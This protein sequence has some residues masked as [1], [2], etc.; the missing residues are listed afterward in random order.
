MMTGENWW[1]GTD[2]IDHR[3]WDAC[4]LV[5]SSPR[6]RSPF[7]DSKVEVAENVAKHVGSFTIA[8]KSMFLPPSR[9]GVSKF[10]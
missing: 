6:K 2:W 7:L 1:V 9:G 8:W 3:C 10:G 4:L 5:Y